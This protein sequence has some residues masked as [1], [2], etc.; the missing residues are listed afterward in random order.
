M[1]ILSLDRHAAVREFA[2]RQVAGENDRAPTR[3]TA[4]FTGGLL[5]GDSLFPPFSDLGQHG[6]KIAFLDLRGRIDVQV[7]DMAAVRAFQLLLANVEREFRS[8]LLTRKNAAASL[9]D[10]LADRLS[11]CAGFLILGGRCRLRIGHGVFNKRAWPGSLP[12]HALSRAGSSSC[13]SWKLQSLAADF[14][15]AV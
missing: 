10:G 2:A 14:I 5:I 12:S 15:E 3:P 1:D 6:L 8:A 7:L 11:G 9:V 13:C 4:D